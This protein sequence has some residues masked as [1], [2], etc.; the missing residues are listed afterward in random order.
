LIYPADVKCSFTASVSQSTMGITELISRP[1]VVKSITLSITADAHDVTLAYI[2]L[3]DGT[4]TLM[5]VL[6]NGVPV[7]LESA[8]TMMF[9]LAGLR[10]EDSFGI[11]VRVDAGTTTKAKGITVL[12]QG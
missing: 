9:P 5:Q 12:Y 4:T 7:Y 8:A 1:C 3:Y 2:L 6:D 10:I 11:G